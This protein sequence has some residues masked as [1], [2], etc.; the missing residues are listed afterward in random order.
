MSETFEYRNIGSDVVAFT[1]QRTLG[2]DRKRLCQMLNIEDENLIIPHQVHSDKVFAVD[3]DFLSL[4]KEQRKEQLEGVDAVITS[5]PGICIGVST[6]DC[7]PILIYDKKTHS[8]A[9]IHAGWRGTV[10]RITRN[11]IRLMEET[12]GSHPEDM[13]AVIGPGISLK[14][15]EIGDEVYN[16]F[17]ESGFNM[18]II[19]EKYKKWHIDLWEAN[20]QILLEC[21]VREENIHIERICTYDNTDSLFSARVEQKG[22]VKCGRNFNAIMLK[23]T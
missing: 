19:A 21:G 12:Y 4:T 13:S 17:V 23:S 2:R 6:A 8:V 10:S 16:K 3:E 11:A 1:T 15:F 22:T 7:I 9:A 20:R 5:I 18:S 14:N